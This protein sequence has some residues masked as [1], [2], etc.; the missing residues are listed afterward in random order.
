M[1]VLLQRALMSEYEITTDS[2]VSVAC[3]RTFTCICYSLQFICNLLKL[4]S[5]LS[6]L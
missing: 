4:I 3:A 5:F 1:F 6:S 2:C